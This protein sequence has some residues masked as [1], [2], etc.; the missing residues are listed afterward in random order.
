MVDH[1]AVPAGAEPGTTPPEGAERSTARLSVEGARFDLPVVHSTLGPEGILISDLKDAGFV[2]VDPGFLTTAQCESKIT[3]IDG[4]ASILRYRGYPIEQLAANSSFLEVAYLLIYGELPTPDQLDSFVTRVNRHTLVHEDFRTF[5]GTFPRNAHPM[6]VLAAA[7]DALSVFYPESRS[8]EDPAAVDLATVLILA[9]VR[10]IVSYIHRRRRNEPL[11]YPDYARGYIDDFLRMSFAHPYE[12]Y[13]S[14][15]LHVEALDRLLILQADHEQNCSTSIVRIVGSANATLYASISAG[16]N[17]LSGPLHGGANEAVLRMLE[18]IR[19]SGKPVREFVE[20][21]KRTKRK[22]AGFGHRV[23]RTYDPRAA[24]AKQYAER[25]LAA[26]PAGTTGDGEQGGDGRG[27]SA[28][29]DLF[30]IAQELE[31]IALHD[32]YFIDRSLWPNI[33]FYTGIVY[34]AIGFQPEMF[35]TLFALGRIPGWIAHWR[36]M[37]A[38][39]MTKIG[40]PRQVYSGPAER[41]YVPA[42]E[43]G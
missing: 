16:V 34:R 2:T 3:Y 1:H 30:D 29:G 42:E 38:D 22:L 17:A 31:D 40:R 5:L 25:V 13:E 4:E 39:P 12:S 41:P 26:Q 8:I 35:T 7:I 15:P 37:H 21:C 23:Y 28:R 43:R 24:I 6:A 36:E 27:A 18:E 33:D 11:L 20:E 9:K 10:T 32:Q 19:G 14:D